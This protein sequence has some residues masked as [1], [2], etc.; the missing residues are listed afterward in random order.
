DGIRDLIVTGVQTCALPIS[1]VRQREVKARAASAIRRRP[2]PAFMFF[3]D[4]PAD[5]ESD[6]H[7]LRLRG[8]ERLERTGQALG[9]R[10]PAR[11]AYSYDHMPVPIA[12]RQDCDLPCPPPD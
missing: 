5:R 2:D 11:V 10:G 4:G 6:S 12:L 7:P 3:D 8:V 9:A 1:P